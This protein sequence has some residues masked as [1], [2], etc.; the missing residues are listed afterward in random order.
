MENITLVQIEFLAIWLA[1][2]MVD[3]KYSWFW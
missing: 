1:D 2:K 3:D